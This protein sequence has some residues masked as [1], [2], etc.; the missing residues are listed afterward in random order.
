MSAFEIDWLALREPY[1][2][3]ARSAALADRF[4]AA[5]GAAPSLIDLGCGTGSNLRYLAPRI[6]GP[7]RWQCV[8]HDPALLDAAR[9]ALQ[10][11]CARRGWPCRSCCGDLILA[12]PGGDIRVEF[13]Q[14]DLA[15][16]GLPARAGAGLTGSA[17]LDLTS[18]AWLEE[19]VAWCGD[20][21]LLI[22]LSFDGRL[23]FEPAMPEDAEV[24]RRFIAHQRTDKGFGKALGPDAA[25]YLAERLRAR[26]RAVTLEPA[27]WRLGPGDVP[28]IRA[29]LAGIVAAAREVRDDPDLERWA[30]LRRHQLAA[31]N[32]RLTIGHLDL[33]ALPD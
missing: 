13:G 24:R 33:L 6:R 5:V 21:P 9:A 26:A 30:S 28:L 27:D 4:A 16:D 8:D 3:A 2:H 15:R 23:A 12:R 18:A 31:G 11:W 32:L 25:P 17:L 7:Q 29:T 10:D 19:L 20:A 14:L 1:D 22:T